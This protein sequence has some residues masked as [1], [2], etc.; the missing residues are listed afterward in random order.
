MPAPS[1][2]F[3]LPPPPPLARLGM[4]IPAPGVSDLQSFALRHP[5]SLRQGNSIEGH[6]VSLRDGSPLS[7]LMNGSGQVEIRCRDMELAG[8]IVQDMASFMKVGRA[9]CGP[10]TVSQHLVFCNWF[11]CLAPRCVLDFGVG[12]ASGV[13]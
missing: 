3:P 1:P 9:A 2:A 7:I 5:D 13:P 12:L 11:L 6:F 4:F 10:S 8:D